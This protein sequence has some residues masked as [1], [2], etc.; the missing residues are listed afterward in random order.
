MKSLFAIIALFGV[1]VTTGC[2]NSQV[3]AGT[4]RGTLPEHVRLFSTDQTAT[5]EVDTPYWHLDNYSFE[6]SHAATFLTIFHTGIMPGDSQSGTI[7]FPNTA[8]VTVKFLAH[9]KV[10]KQLQ[11]EPT[12]A[13][14]TVS[15][16]S[17]ASPAAGH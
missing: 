15:N 8:A 3:Q 16:G 4:A 2:S 12:S 14:P 10:V 6:R 17:P 7:S 5:V 11:M 13:T 1:L 9:D